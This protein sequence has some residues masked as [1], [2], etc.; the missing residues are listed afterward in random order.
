MT[1]SK[2]KHSYTPHVHSDTPNNPICTIGFKMNL[3]FSLRFIQFIFWH[4]ALVAMVMDGLNV[5]CAEAELDDG[6]VLITHSQLWYFSIDM[7]WS[8]SKMCMLWGMCGR[9][10]HNQSMPRFICTSSAEVFHELKVEHVLKWKTIVS[11]DTQFKLSWH[12]HRYE[13]KLALIYLPWP[14]PSMVSNLR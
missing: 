13:P 4:N 9:K 8:H 5:H 11:I 12:F 14:K 2:C 6:Y 1:D 10:W 7:E 3:E